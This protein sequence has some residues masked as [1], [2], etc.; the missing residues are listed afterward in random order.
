[1]RCA[2][3]QLSTQVPVRVWLQPR[4]ALCCW[5][6]AWGRTGH[7]LC[8]AEA[9]DVAGSRNRSLHLTWCFTLRR[10]MACPSLADLEHVRHWPPPMLLQMPG[11]TLGVLLACLMQWC[12]VAACLI[13]HEPL[14]HA[15]WQYIARLTVFLKQ[16]LIEVQTA[17][18]AKVF[19]CGSLH[20]CTA[21]CQP[22]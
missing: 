22:C 18:V 13:A 21:S 4:W 5:T 7:T 2:L 11:H 20:P 17:K 16:E 1:M 12:Q 9:C 19:V 15:L 14:A 10:L 3:A 6:A 8:F